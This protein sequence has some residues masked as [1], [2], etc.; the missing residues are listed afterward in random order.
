M[1]TEE[2]NT[3]KV[4]EGHRSPMR[5]TNFPPANC[6][7]PSHPPERGQKWGVATTDTTF[8]RFTSPEPGNSQR[9]L[10]SGWGQQ[11]WEISPNPMGSN[12]PQGR[13]CCWLGASAMNEL[14]A[15]RGKRTK[16][17]NVVQIECPSRPISFALSATVWNYFQCQIMAQNLWVEGLGWARESEVIR[18]EMLSSHYSYF[19]PFSHNT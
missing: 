18:V 9:K 16:G 2:E 3:T 12:E 19:T 7:Q 8:P 6:R 1:A 4:C 5:W 15:Q 17:S 13:C 11:K 14:C 10:V